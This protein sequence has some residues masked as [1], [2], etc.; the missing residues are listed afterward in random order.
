MPGVK[1]HMNGNKDAYFVEAGSYQQWDS[2]Q[3]T[4]IPKGP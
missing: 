2:A 3:Q 1:F 4:W